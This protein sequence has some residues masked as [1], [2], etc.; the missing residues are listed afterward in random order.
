MKDEKLLLPSNPL[1]K[2]EADEYVENQKSADFY[3]NIGQYMFW[4][5]TTV[6]AGVAA[7]FFSPTILAG[8][9]SATTAI[10]IGGIVSAATFAGSLL[11]SRK[12]I[13]IS[14]KGNVLYSDIDSR[15]QAHRMVQEFA[16]AQTVGEVS[17]E[18]VPFIEHSTEHTDQKSSTHQGSWQAKVGKD[19]QVDGNWAVRVAKMADVEDA[20][21]KSAFAQ[22]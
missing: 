19:I 8:A 12:A 14:E 6:L 22:I 7:V 5:A 2:A 21:A 13:E 10:A 17:K 18:V 20:Q 9:M 16:R 4:G 11:F 3:R 15:Q 1:V